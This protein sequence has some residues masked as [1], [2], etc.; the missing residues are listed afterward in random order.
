MLRV[1]VWVSVTEGTY[2]MF[3]SSDSSVWWFGLVVTS[4]ALVTSTKL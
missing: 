3:T 4:L 1:T 2:L